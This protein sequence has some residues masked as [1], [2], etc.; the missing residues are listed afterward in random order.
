MQATCRRFVEDFNMHFRVSAETQMTPEVLAEYI[1]KH[2]QAVNVRLKRLSDAYRNDYQIYHEARKPDGKPDSRVSVNFAKYI[3]DTFNGFFCGIPIKEAS[4]DEVVND[5]L[6]QLGAYND[7]ENNDCELAKQSSIFGSAHEMYFIDDAGNEG[8]TYISPLNSFFLVDDSI[9]RKPLFF[10]HYY[11]DSD[12]I[13]RG[14]WSDAAVVQHF[15]NRGSYR[16]EDEPKVH[17]FVDVPATEYSE[18]DEQ[19]GIFESVLPMIDSYNRAI[20]DKANDVD[21]FSDAYM[22]IVG[23]QMQPSDVNDIR[24]NRVVNL[25]SDDPEEAA[26][27]NAD[28]MQRPSGDSTQENL[29]DRLERLIYQVSMV[30]NISDENFGTS[31]GIAL[32]YKLQA[33]SNLA[34]I[35]ERKFR[36]G[37]NRRYR[38]LFSNP[39]IVGSGVTADDW[40]KVKATFTMNYPANVSDEADTAAKLSGVVSKETQLSV[41]SIVDN[42]KEEIERMSKEQESAF[43]SG[44]DLASEGNA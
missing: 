39:V 22:K 30:A 8:I 40:M 44:Y 43:P 5:F 27:L 36:S 38:I 19:I 10:V 29:L 17:G 24:N 37:M 26:A 18:N 6:Q 34:K 25:W 16:W 42:P 2:K 33:M 9:L 41:L 31:S 4:D 35:K 11:L 32:R 7:Q 14:S 12:N 15:V 28:F 20:S 3:T 13:E 21:Y 1:T 23:K